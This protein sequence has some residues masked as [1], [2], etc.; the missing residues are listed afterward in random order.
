MSDPVPCTPCCSSTVQ[1]VNTPGTTGASAITTTTANFTI[2]AIGSTVLISCGDTSWLKAFKNLFVSDGSGL[3]NFIVTAVN[4]ATSFTGKFLGFVGDSAAGTTIQSGAIVIPGIGD[5]TVPWDLDALTA[6]TDS[7]GGTK[8]DTIAASGL[9]STVIIPIQ[10]T[11]YVNATTLKIA[12]PFAFTVNS[13]LLRVSKAGTGAG[14]SITLQTQISAAATTGGS[15]T[16]TLANSATVG[17]TVA[18]TAITGSNTGTAGQTLE[19]AV[20]VGTVFTA[21]DGWFE[22]N[23]TNLDLAATLAAIAFKANQ[24]RTALRHQ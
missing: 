22:L 3:A 15:V 12:V 2:P 10:F 13:V 18:G 20:T 16:S 21:G 14:A 9:K 19:L 24:L 4:S 17:G 5:F 23:V 7:S 6:F 1:T 11:D 8:S